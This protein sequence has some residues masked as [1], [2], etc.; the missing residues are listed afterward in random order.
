MLVDHNVFNWLSTIEGKAKC[1][2]YFEINHKYLSK[3]WI[4]EK[5]RD[6]RKFLELCKSENMNEQIERSVI[7]HKD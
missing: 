5:T 6:S 1:H 7:Q 3:T 2:H 4:R